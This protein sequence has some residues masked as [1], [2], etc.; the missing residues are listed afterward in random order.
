MSS[1]LD[2][3]ICIVISV[4]QMGKVYPIVLWV[5]LY[6]YVCVLFLAE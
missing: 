3:K 6:R 5:C 1:Y 2:E 4:E